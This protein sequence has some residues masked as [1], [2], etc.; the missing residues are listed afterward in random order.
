LPDSVRTFPACPSGTPDSSLCQ[1]IEA[2]VRLLFRDEADPLEQ[3]S[4]FQ[5]ALSA[6]IADGRLGTS[7]AEVNPQS[8]AAVLAPVGE[9][10]TGLSG[11]AIAGICIA[12]LVVVFL[13]GYGYH[14]SQHPAKTEEQKA[15]LEPIET[16]DKKVSPA[17]GSVG[18]DHE[19]DG[20]GD[21]S[22]ASDEVYTIPEPIVATTAAAA[23]SGKLLGA[24]VPDYGRTSKKAV[25]AMEAGEDIVAEPELDIHPD[26]SSNAG[27]SG[28]SSS[29]GISSLNTG[30]VDDSMDQAAAL[31][32]TLASIGATSALTQK[33][34]KDRTR[35]A[36]YVLS[37]HKQRWFSSVRLTM[38]LDFH[39]G[40]SQA[41]RANRRDRNSTRSL[42]LVTGRL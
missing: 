7:L 21:V 1:N 8:R 23:A 13:A 32:A 39:T 22:I 41:Q 34:A 18:P 25:E 24:S 5:T 42:R 31:G 14:K 9:S 26:S 15:A 3:V 16:E 36:L 17:V 19:R 29:A 38:L 6:A 33:G 2:T 12:A 35:S 27:S 11:G 37:F 28:W 20:A 30:S 4:T 40:T 10:T